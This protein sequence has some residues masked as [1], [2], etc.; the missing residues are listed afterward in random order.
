LTFDGRAALKQLFADALSDEADFSQILVYDVSRWG[1]FQDVDEPAYHEHLCRRHG[2]DVIYCAESFE[3]DGSLIA[4]MWKSFMRSDLFRRRLL[5]NDWAD[6][7]AGDAAPV[8]LR[9][10]A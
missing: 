1:R 3:N 5:M 9:V 7:L 10:I 2:I 8:V 4:A 6:Y